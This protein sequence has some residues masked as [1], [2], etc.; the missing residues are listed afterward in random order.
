LFFDALYSPIVSARSCKLAGLRISSEN[1]PSFGKDESKVQSRSQW[2]LANSLYDHVIEQITLLGFPLTLI[3]IVFGCIAKRAPNQ[4]AVNIHCP[5]T[6]GE[7]M[8]LLMT[9]TACAQ[10]LWLLGHFSCGWLLCFACRSMRYI[11][12]GCRNLRKDRGFDRSRG[13][14]ST[15]Y[16]SNDNRIASRLQRSIEGFIVSRVGDSA[17]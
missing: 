1:R 14:A 3:D 11:L 5:C 13:R 17:C 12:P 6:V 15:G 9:S 10:I 16:S 8:A 2:R 7:Y 4:E